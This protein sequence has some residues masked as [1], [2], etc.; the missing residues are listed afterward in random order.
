MY[1]FQYNH[2]KLKYLEKAKL[3][4]EYRNADSFIV[5]ITMDDIYKDIADNVYT[6]FET[7]NYELEK[8]KKSK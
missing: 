6:R 2:I 5:Y 4:Y 3:L 1:E 8:Q 7:S